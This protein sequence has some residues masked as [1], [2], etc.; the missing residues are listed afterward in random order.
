M[1]VLSSSQPPSDGSIDGAEPRANEQT[2]AD[3][4]S[5]RYDRALVPAAR[6]LWTYPKGMYS[7]AELANLSEGLLMLGFSSEEVVTFL[8]G[9][10]MPVFDA[11]WKPA[12]A[13]AQ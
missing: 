2:T 8:G 11:V 6:F 4:I 1:G 9:N 3:V 13:N 7:H 10:F 5:Q 12:S